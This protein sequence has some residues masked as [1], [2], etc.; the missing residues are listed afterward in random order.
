L[1][2]LLLTSSD[3]IARFVTINS[4]TDITS[5]ENSER[6]IHLFLKQLKEEKDIENQQV[7]K[8]SIRS[9]KYWL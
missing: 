1:E 3:E 9:L 6:T 5:E 7:L 2:N 4:L 8:N